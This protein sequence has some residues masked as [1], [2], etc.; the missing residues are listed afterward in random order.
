MPNQGLVWCILGE[1]DRMVVPGLQCFLQETSTDFEDMTLFAGHHR[2]GIPSGKL[3]QLWK[4]TMFN[5]KTHYKWPFSM[6]MLNCQRVQYPDV[7]RDTVMGPSVNA[8]KSSQG[9]II[10]AKATGNQQ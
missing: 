4:I 7:L 9:S 3:T 8:P 6:A 1:V 2:E 10:K 5:G